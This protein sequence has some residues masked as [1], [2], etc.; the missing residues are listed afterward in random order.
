ML[1][2]LK[3][4]SKDS[5]AYSISNI[6]TRAS[7]F[8]MLPIY[9][10]LFAPADIGVINLINVTYFFISS[11]S[12]FCLDSAAIV[13]APF[14]KADRAAIFNWANGC[15][16]ILRLLLYKN[17]K[18]LNNPVKNMSEKY[19]PYLSVSNTKLEKEPEKRKAG[20]AT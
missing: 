11:V 17:G 9:A 8:I 7:S 6:I 19:W 18:T 20:T 15:L 13:N 16:F 1:G 12:L 5:F 3:S 2:H 14:N 4:L 10:R